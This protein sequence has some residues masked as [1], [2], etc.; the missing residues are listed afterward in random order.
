MGTR[1]GTVS[2]EVHIRTDGRTVNERVVKD[3]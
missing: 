1:S 2:G 3:G